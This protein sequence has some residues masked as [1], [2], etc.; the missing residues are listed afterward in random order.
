MLEAY[1]EETGLNRSKIVNAVLESFFSSKTLRERL[2]EAIK[3]EAE[4]EQLIAEE[5]RLFKELKVILRSGVYL[6]EAQ[7]KLLLGMNPG[8]ISRLKQS[9]GIYARMDNNQREAV[10]RIFDRRKVIAD[11]LVQIEIQTLPES[12]LTVGYG[13]FGELEILPKVSPGEFV[14]SYVRKALSAEG[15]GTESFVEWIKKERKLSK[16]KIKIEG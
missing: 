15:P 10:M 7:K 8:E 3:L 2:K 14:T 4:R 5:K 6:E 13:K 1:A 11:R 16:G 12:K 9:E